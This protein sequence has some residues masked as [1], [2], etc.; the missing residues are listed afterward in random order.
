MTQAAF[1]ADLV[2][3][4]H[5]A[6]VAYLDMA[7]PDDI[8]FIDGGTNTRAHQAHNIILEFMADNGYQAN[9]KRLGIPDRW[10]EHGS[11]LELHKECGFDPEGIAAATREL[12][13]QR[14]ERSASQTMAG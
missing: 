8:H 14:K 12:V 6:V 9:V 1:L 5:A 11:Q 7:P 13:E 10:V 2:L 3:A 4:L